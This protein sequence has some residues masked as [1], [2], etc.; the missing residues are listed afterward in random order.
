MGGKAHHPSSSESDYWNDESWTVDCPCGVSF[1]D[2]EEMV[3]CDECG[4]WVHTACC[5]VPKG[6][7]TFVC[8]KCKSKKKKEAEEVPDQLPSRHASPTD[9]PSDGVAVVALHPPDLLRKPANEV[10]MHERVHVQGP[11]GGDPQLFQDVSRVFSQQL[12]KFTGYVPKSFHTKCKDIPSWPSPDDAPER[13]LSLLSSRKEVSVETKDDAKAF[14]RNKENIGNNIKKGTMITLHLE[15]HGKRDSKK[16]EGKHIKLGHKS[17]RSHRDGNRVHLHLKRGSDDH[18]DRKDSFKRMRTGSSLKAEDE[19]SK[20][21]E[22]SRSEAEPALG[23]KLPVSSVKNPKAMK[24]M[25][26]QE[27]MDGHG[28]LGNRCSFSEQ[29]QPTLA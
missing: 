22:L 18:K 2:G 23:E 15:K 11:P 20:E 3:E 13:L 5:R 14:E 10:P 17:S 12:W 26:V 4:V 29:M 27:F 9:I 21:D 6:L 16:G 19:L 1:D 7:P 28:A 24:K 8:D 25:A